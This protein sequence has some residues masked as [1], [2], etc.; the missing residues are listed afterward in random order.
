MAFPSSWEA[1]KQKV[2]DNFPSVRQLSTF[3][4]NNMLRAGQTDI[5]LLD[6]REKEEFDISHL[7]GA[8]WFPPGSDPQKLQI[9]KSKRVVCYC[10]VGWRSS[11]MAEF[12]E[13]AGFQDVYNLEGSIFEWANQGRKVVNAQGRSRKVHP[14]DSSWG[15]F[16]QERFRWD[17]D[18]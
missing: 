12:L 18:S 10:S 13:E 11:E 2:R 15:R 14:Y 5:V 9:P 1:F 3:E 16:L 7:P 6:V 17:L 4:L 8:V